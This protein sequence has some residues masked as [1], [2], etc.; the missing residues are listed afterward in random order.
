MAGPSPIALSAACSG[1][2]LTARYAA[3]TDNDGSLMLRHEVGSRTTYLVRRH[4]IRGRI[5]LAELREDE[6]ERPLIYVSD[7]DVLERYLFGLFADDIRDDL[8]LPFIELPWTTD[9]LA[10]G[11]TLSEMREGYRSL[12]RIGSGPIAA[13]PDPV[14]S[15]L[16]LVP[17]SHFMGW[18]VS[19]LKRAFLGSGAPVLDS[20]GRYAPAGRPSR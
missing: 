2:A 11:F 19:D 13:A 8:D 1:W 17:L 10:E 3:F 12:S 14:L 6:S 7:L 16:A 20:S 5:F 4:K 18:E 15:L 9:D